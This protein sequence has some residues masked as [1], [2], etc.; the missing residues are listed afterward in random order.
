MKETIQDIKKDIVGIFENKSQECIYRASPTPERLRKNKR[1]AII[2]D[3]KVEDIELFY[4][5]YRFCEEG[6]DVDVITE[7]GGAFAGKGGACLKDSK[8]I[9]VVNSHDYELLYLPGGKAPAKLRKNEK[10]LKFVRDFAGSRKIIAAICHGPQILISAGLIEGKTI[11]AWPEIKGEIEESGA[12]FSDQALQ[13]DGQFITA[14]KPGDLPRHLYG[15]LN[16]L[17]AQSS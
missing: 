6:Y 12:I 1:I 15:I 3:E 11:A 8:S 7:N 13:E 4:P 14:R 5:Y 2:T 17:N 16:K 9:D 10:V